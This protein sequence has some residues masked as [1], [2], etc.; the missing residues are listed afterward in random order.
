M[1]LAPKD[2]S[3]RGKRRTRT[4]ST[5]IPGNRRNVDTQSPM[6]GIDE[7]PCLDVCVAHRWRERGGANSPTGAPRGPWP[8]HGVTGVR[9]VR[10]NE[11]VKRIHVTLRTSYYDGRRR[12]RVRRIDD[13]VV[14]D[15]TV[16]YYLQEA[17]LRH[18][19]TRVARRDKTQFHVS[20]SS[21]LPLVHS[22]MPQPQERP[23]GVYRITNKKRRGTPLGQVP[24]PMT[25][26]RSTHASRN[27]RGGTGRAPTSTD[28]RHERTPRTGTCPA[29]R[30][31]AAKPRLSLAELHAHTLH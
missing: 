29:A 5:L 9:C 22:S 13:S 19:P 6:M 18:P 26:R 16:S 21:A 17:I 20:V 25:R 3:R 8:G 15:T 31:R 28:A 10:E 30:G 14:K 11:G 2:P 23:S 27:R 7:V 1:T 4:H 24:R 12:R